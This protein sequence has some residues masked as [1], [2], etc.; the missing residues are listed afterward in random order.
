[1]KKI[2][3]NF[4]LGPILSGC[5]TFIAVCQINFWVSW[6]CYIPLFISISN[7]ATKNILKKGFVFGM[8]FSAAAFYWMIPGAERFTGNS[9]FY[10]ICVFIISS[11]FVSIYYTLIIYC[12]YK[13]KRQESKSLAVFI[14]GVL[15]AS[16]F[17]IA[18]AV[19]KL[20]T[21]EFPWF[22]IHGGNGLAANDY[23]IQ[24]AAIFGVHLLTFI[25]V[26]VN[27]LFAY[28][29][30]KKLWRKLYIPVTVI[31]IYI[32]GGFLL[33][34]NF[35]AKP[36]TKQPFKVAILAENIPPEMKWDN[37]NG[38]YLVQKLL[39]LN[40]SAV[41]LKPD[42]ALWSE[43]AIPWTYKKD[44]DLVNKIL[45]I[46]APA[47]I[48][49]ILGINTAY[50]EKEN[51]IL[52]SAYCILPDGTVTSRYD[53]Q[54]LLA[55]IEKPVG[56]VMMPFLS[57]AGFSATTNKQHGAPLNTPFGKAGMLICNEAALPA[58]AASMVNQGAQFLFNISNDGWFNDTYIVRLHFYYA[59]L[60]AVESRKDLAIN[61]NNGYSGLIKASGIISEM[62]RSDEPFV[63]MVE[64]HPN[65]IITLAGAMPDLFVY[66]C[67]AYLFFIALV[68]FIEKAKKRA[69]AK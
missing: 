33:L 50:N 25:V 12:I 63:K 16:L 7:D 65:N 26:V 39:N 43:S 57:I 38:N 19:L 52:N 22:D 55:F 4:W 11:L 62:E 36:A 5:L 58:A 14:N 28:Y 46:T 53:K 24:P 30:S 20:I 45:S 68:I 37:A 35:D 34:Q 42:M 9:V 51:I 66:T 40:R 8:V 31:L 69:I 3:T 67:A 56:G 1:M 54:Y 59:R 64:I 29:L 15:F 49:H 61:S 10:G 44:D 27:Y 23:A 41:A 21:V 32:A 47:R 17:C 48:T 2:A 18:D 13:L 6:I 60:R